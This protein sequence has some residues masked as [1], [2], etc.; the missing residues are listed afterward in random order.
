M[1]SC[2]S[3]VVWKCLLNAQEGSRDLSILLL[4]GEEGLRSIHTAAQNHDSASVPG[5]PGSPPAHPAC[6]LASRLNQPFQALEEAGDQEI[7]ASL[8]LRKKLQISLCIPPQFRVPTTGSATLRDALNP[9]WQLPELQIMTRASSPPGAFAHTHR[10][11]HQ[12]LCHDRLGHR[13]LMHLNLKR[14]T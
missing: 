8:C 12:T 5:S 4:E 13:C 9:K 6:S 14:N 2:G 11:P 7:G 10:L 1:G 3:A